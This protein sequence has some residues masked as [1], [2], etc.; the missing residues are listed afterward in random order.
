MLLDPACFGGFAMQV[1]EKVFLS[2]SNRDKAHIQR[3]TSALGMAREKVWWDQELGG[4]LE[5][6][7]TII[8]QIQQCDVF[9][10]ALSQ[11]SLDSTACR[12]ELEYAQALGKPVFPVQVGPVTDIRSTPFAATQLLDYRRPQDSTGIRLIDD[13]RRLRRSSP[14]L[15]Q[16]MPPEPPMPY[17]FLM[18]WNAE[19]TDRKLLPV[20]QLQLL[21]EMV[22]RL[23]EVGD[24]S[25]ARKDIARSLFQ[26]HDRADTDP[27]VRAAVESLAAAQDLDRPR[28]G[29][30]LRKWLF[31]GAAL[32]LVA[33]VAATAVFVWP[34]S[35]LVT[36]SEL[37]GVLLTEEEVPEVLG[38]SDLEYGKIDPK[39]SD[40]QAETI[41]EACLGAFY[42]ANDAVY[43]KSGIKA[44]RNQ[45]LKVGAPDTVV[46]YQSAIR[47]DSPDRA[48]DFVRAS[49]ENWKGCANQ[50]VEVKETTPDGT[51]LTSTW[52]FA[53]LEDQGNQIV[54]RVNQ[55]GGNAACQHVLHAAEN[56]IIE[57]NACGDRVS[58]EAQ[59]IAQAMAA[60]MPE[61]TG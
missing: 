59:R 8:E 36:L 42:N 58:D 40:N 57:V 22:S 52:K 4:G 7:K 32:L 19:L 20:K 61:V 41:P 28:D 48:A 54:Q 3:V 39:T 55:D 23:N 49:A 53:P 50:L 11:H 51:L 15:P 10:L 56:V 35:K 31:A 26:L 43:K 21:N 47:F 5:W 2:Y 27:E 46:I 13:V 24:D 30:F 17:E 18:R 38:K 6:W 45:P 12:A 1:M 33:V 9:I 44:S 14:P 37:G 25:T 60:K 34:G 16:H 29:R